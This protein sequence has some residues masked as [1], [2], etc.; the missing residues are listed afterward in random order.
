MGTAPVTPSVAASTRA[1]EVTLRPVVVVTPGQV[2]AARVIEATGG[3]LELAVAGTRVT[4]ASDLPLAAGD[5]VRLEV[6]HADD[7]RI[8][9]RLL[10]PAGAGAAGAD[11]TAADTPAGL[12][13]AAARALEAALR[14][15][16]A[17]P[18]G[19]GGR[20]APGAAGPVAGDRGLGA[21]LIERAR[22]ADVRTPAQAAALV[23]L[24][25][26]GLPLTPALVA[27]LADL[28]EGPPL[29]RALALLAPAAAPSGAPSA[30]AAAPAALPPA[31]SAPPAG[32]SSPVAGGAAPPPAA[33][34][35]DPARTAAPAAAL[36]ALVAGIAADAVSGDGEAVRRARVRLGVTAPPGPAAGPATLH[37]LL[38]RLATDPATP[39]AQARGAERAAEALAAQPAVPPAL[40]PAAD[41][42]Q[43]GA[44]MQ[45]PLPGGRTA[46]V[47]VL[48]DGGGEGGEGGRGGRPTRVAFLLH[49]DALG[50]LTVEAVVGEAAVDALVRSPAPGVRAFLAGRAPE[51]ADALAGLR[52][53]GP[54]PRVG[55]EPLGESAPPRLAPAPPATG[56]DLSA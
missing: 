19:A 34:G 54:R 24:A 37:D 31:P 46:E 39:A 6:A 50:P 47:R 25:A 32:G 13:R 42:T 7:E 22:A 8:V 5:T 11:G 29:G 43:A 21:A 40:L 17:V 48:P 30:P 45:I 33:A 2:L 4:A 23:R 15:V 44:Y 10:P 28:S 52:P 49:M 16:L 51:L 35:P 20:A 41:P 18:A 1:P 27:G 12:P 9:L 56:L 14:E 36:A 3:R 55:V 53:D 38:L 26:A